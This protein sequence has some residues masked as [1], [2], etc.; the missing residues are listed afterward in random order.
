MKST[1]HHIIA[2]T[3]F[4]LVAFT[5]CKKE[6]AAVHNTSSPIVISSFEPQIGTGGTEV[7]ISGS[8]FTTDTSQLSV[9]INGKKLKIIASNTN[10]MMVVISKKVGSGPI[11]ITIGAGNTTSAGVFNYQYTRTVSTLA[12]SGS[13]GF[14]NGQGTNASFSFSGQNWYRSSGI[15]ADSKLNV[16]VA[17]PG[18]HCIRK[19]DTAGNVTTFSGNPASSGYADGKGTAAQYVLPYGL[20]IDSQDNIYCVDP[21]NYDVRKISPD[22]T[23]VTIG[24]AGQSPWSVAVDNKTGYVYFTGN[25]NPAS[26]YQLTAP[27]TTNEIITGL[28][29]AAGIA[30]DSSGNIYVSTSDQVIRKFTAGTWAGSI[31]AGQL[32]QTGYVDGAANAAKFA[33]PMGLAVDAANNIYVGENATYDGGTSNP[34]QSVRYIDGKTLVVSTFAGSQAAGFVN[35]DGA[36]AS[37]S[38]PNGVAVDKNGTVYVLD[39]N[40]NSVR[41]IVS[42]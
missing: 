19:I 11:K 6:K 8:N 31:L 3:A 21:I 36:A 35:G 32:N 22:G 7:L 30:L 2:V 38:A 17:D 4:I 9:T 34:D 23:A 16:Y 40:N 15:V 13:A 10:Q 12:G 27:F 25:N 1:Y 20:A 33:Y 28:F 14:L 39:K 29:Y 18:N 26:V 42:Q 41:K 37:F 24:W 5:S